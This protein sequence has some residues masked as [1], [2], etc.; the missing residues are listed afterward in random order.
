MEKKWWIDYPWRLIQTNL[1]EIDMADIDAERYV[2]ELKAFDATVAMINTSGIIA[3][4]QT[5][6]DFHYQSPFLTGDSLQDII[7]ACHRANIRVIARMDFSKV[8]RPL[9]EAHPEWAYRKK[10]GGIVDYNGDVHVCICG[11]YQQKYSLRIIE[12][13]VRKLD[14]DGIFFNMGGFYQSDYSGNNH[15]LC[16][17][18]SCKQRFRK[19]SGFDLPE[20]TS[21]I[22][23]VFR[24]YRLFQQQVVREHNKKVN[25]LITSINPNICIC[26]FSEGGFFRL[27]SNTGIDRPLP[28]WQYCAADN[29]KFVASSFGHD[30]VNSNTTVDFID[31]P[32]RHAAVSPS[33]QRLRLYQNLAQGGRLDYYLIGRLD[34]HRDRSGYAGIKEVFAFHT[35]NEDTYRSL[36]SLAKIALVKD[37]DGN[38]EEYCG[39]YRFLAE[40][41]YLFDAPLKSRLTKER[42][43]KYDTVILPDCMFVSGSLAE[44]LDDFVE[45]GGK[46]ISVYRSAT[47]NDRY[48]PLTKPAMKCLG[49][50][51]ILIARTDMRGSYF[52]WEKGAFPSL[53]ETELIYLDD[54]YIYA[55][56]STDTTKHC[57]L[58]PPQPFGPP[59]R[60]YPTVFSDHPCF[61]TRNYG[62]GKAMFIPWKPGKFFY[63]QGYSSYLRFAGDLLGH[64]L[65]VGKVKTDLPEMAEIT[66]H[67]DTSGRFDLI[68]IVNNTGHFGV[69]FY[70][71]VPLAGYSLELPCTR[72]VNRAIGLVSGS[73]VEFSLK[74]GM[75]SLKLPKLNMYEAIRIE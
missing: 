36:E 41:H 72:D 19:F 62:K 49:I 25:E 2:R 58:I 22:N 32:A 46:L 4:Y 44:L 28:H 10:D 51:N 9:Y 18:E 34:N 48:E 33:Q 64:V 59:E 35:R 12:E 56:Y 13:T 14:I 24:A 47:A 30:T 15:G 26:S 16:H 74:D 37:I 38:N 1:R 20:N 70:E 75:L 21:L 5:G 42:L 71:P 50:E 57:K 61:V 63:R 69:S 11:D 43:E 54:S 53:P 6:L 23:P 40:N 66:Y 52:E 73:D 55:A 29:T 45:Q 68:S 67:T 39:W 65:G 3:S 60:T 17:C 8:R 31:F 7:E 27:E